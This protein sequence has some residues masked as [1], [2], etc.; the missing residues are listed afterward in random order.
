MSYINVKQAIAMIQKRTKQQC[1][2]F[3][4]LHYIAN[5]QIDVFIDNE[6]HGFDIC[7]VSLHGEHDGDWVALGIDI[8]FK[9]MLRLS[10]NEEGKINRTIA[11]NE[12]MDLVEVHKPPSDKFKYV[13]LA[14][15]LDER[16]RRN[17]KAWTDDWEKPIDLPDINQK[18]GIGR[19]ISKDA[20]LF[21]AEQIESL[22][23]KS[24]IKEEFTNT[25]KR[26]LKAKINEGIGS[27]IC[28]RIHNIDTSLPN[29][30]VAEYVSSI[31]KVLDLEIEP[32]TITRNW[33]WVGKKTK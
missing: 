5:N 9:G 32:E 1:S 16:T 13:L 17:L 22:R 11:L 8:D 31:L 27:E 23:L 26:N 14:S 29:V 28:N 12:P 33:H 10:A 19:P 30:Q 20:L 6:I 24:I 4:L 18:L 3:T 7:H 21:D 25:H 15:K 2:E